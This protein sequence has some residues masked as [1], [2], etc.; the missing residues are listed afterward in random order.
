[1]TL[2]REH[3]EQGTAS[4]PPAVTRAREYGIDV[5]LIHGNLQRTVA[6]RLRALDTNAEFVRVLR[7]RVVR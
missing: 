5:S 7:D 3:P 6:E 4:E 2:Q 1:M